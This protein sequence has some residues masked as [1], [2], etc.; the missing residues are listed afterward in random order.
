LIIN[1]EKLYEL[2]GSLE[3][4]QEII[5]LYIEKSP[6]LVLNLE[7]A[8]L[9][10]NQNHL[11]QICHKGIGQARY[12]ASETI[13]KALLDIQN[14]PMIEKDIHLQTLKAIIQQLH[15]EHS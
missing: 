6:E 9:T 1:E 4:A 13:E 8:L 10:N 7:Q 3:S 5:N 2:Y 15:H 12:I 11:E 14:A